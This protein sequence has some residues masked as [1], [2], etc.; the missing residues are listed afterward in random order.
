MGI[1]TCHNRSNFNT[2]N[3]TG[4]IHEPHFLNFSNVKVTTKVLRNKLSDKRMR[5]LK[6]FLIAMENTIHDLHPR[7]K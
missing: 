5:D 4:E 7:H 6:M 1:Y 2:Q 3:L